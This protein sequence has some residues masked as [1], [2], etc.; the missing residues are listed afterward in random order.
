MADALDILRKDAFQK[1]IHGIPGG[2][3]ILWGEKDIIQIYDRLMS[4]RMEE[5]VERQTAPETKLLGTADTDKSALA[6]MGIELRDIGAEGDPLA[7]IGKIT[8]DRV[9]LANDRITPS[10][11]DYADFL[12]F[13]GVLDTHD[14]SK[15]PVAL[16]TQPWLSGASLLAIANFPRPGVSADSDRVA[17]AVR[18]SLQ[19]GIS[20][21][22]VPRR[23]SFSKDPARPLGIDFH[24]SSLLEWSFCSL[25]CNQDCR[26]LGS[27]ANNQSAPSDGKTA[28]RRREARVLA[29]KARA[30]CASIDDEPL[31]PPT[32][33]Q[34]MAEARAVRRIVLAG[35]K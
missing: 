10:A 5:I 6:K 32:R 11:I 2:N 18:A 12:K 34:R 14:S 23:W 1:R 35:E 27:V 30:L 25:P 8:S 21:G 24:E 3:R 19:R 29:A 13:R 33:E 16:S 20:I 22:F 26:V 17:A 9:D 15:P 28:D 7:V 31:A 4:V